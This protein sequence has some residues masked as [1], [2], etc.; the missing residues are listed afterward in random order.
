M[1]KP[2]VKYLISTLIT[3][4]FL[5]VANFLTGLVNVLIADR[6]MITS[7]LGLVMQVSDLVLGTVFYFVA[8]FL[9]YLL[10]SK[11]LMKGAAR[12]KQSLL[13]ALV[14]TAIAHILDQLVG[15]IGTIALVLL[16]YTWSTTWFAASTVVSCLLAILGAFLG[17]MICLREKKV[18]AYMA[19]QYMPYGVPQAP[20]AAPQPPAEDPAQNI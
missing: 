12:V 17:S 19:P 5:F 16:G 20:Y 15:L 7:I 9:A 10:G 1:K 2:F 11:L 13:G 18:P 8:A 14:C 4:V 6:V 3:L